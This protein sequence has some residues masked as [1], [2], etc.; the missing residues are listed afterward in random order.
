MRRQTFFMIPGLLVAM[1][2]YAVI[3]L[4]TL[5]GRHALLN[6]AP[7][8]RE[9]VQGLSLELPAGTPGPVQVPGE[10]W[11]ATEFH[12]GVLGDFRVA[13]ERARGDFQGAMQAWFALPGPLDGPLTFRQHGQPTL[14]RPVIV[15]G[16]GGQVVRRQGRQ[17]VAV[18]VFDLDGWRYWVQSRVRDGAREH[19]VCF[20][21][22][23]L[24]MR[25]PSG[26]GVDAL[27]AP[28][29]AA[30]EAGL[31]LGLVQDPTW[32][33]ALPGVGMLLVLVVVFGVT[34][35]SGRP[36][37]EA[38]AASY[39]ASGVEVSLGGRLQ[40]KYFDAAL[41][42][43]GGELVVYT[44]GTPF[45]AVPL[46]R[47]RGR[48]TE[49]TSWFGPPCLAINLEGGADFRKNRFLYGLWSGRLRLR[50]YTEDLPR[51]RLALG[52]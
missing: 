24:S 43:Q 33:L 51:L 30:V 10:P 37:R 50:I 38:E 6:P 28:A 35:L 40:R 18:C 19:L 15:F 26:S 41:A 7:G 44:F 14:A 52:A 45:L 11:T 31:P 5:Q 32:V 3:A 20:D 2:A 47:L 34:R 39:V 27:L 48:V 16:P 17:L 12:G 1:T 13:R 36:P 29:L 8:R 9:T 23:L 46:D 21:R 25:A 22:V 49:D 4:H 42:V